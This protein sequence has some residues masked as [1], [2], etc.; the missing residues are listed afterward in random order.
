MWSSMCSH[1][2]GPAETLEVGLRLVIN[3]TI[4]R[5][6]IYEARLLLVK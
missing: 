4:Y 6:I 3:E 2:T 1:A 5:N